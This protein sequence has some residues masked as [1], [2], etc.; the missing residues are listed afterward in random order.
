MLQFA[1]APASRW[2]TTLYSSP[3]PASGSRSRSSS[4]QRLLTLRPGPPLSLCS[5]DGIVP[6]PHHPRTGPQLG[7]RAVIPDPEGRRLS[8]EEVFRNS[9]D[10][11][12]SQPLWSPL[13]CLP[14]STSFSHSTSC[15]S[16]QTPG[17][18]RPKEEATYCPSRRC[19]GSLRVTGRISLV[20]SWCPEGDGGDWVAG[21]LPGPEDPPVPA[22]DGRL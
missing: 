15:R 12:S 1:E 18:L 9:L 7:E 11:S 14:I 4:P 21:V 3:T 16:L 20:A 5:L 22:M 19:V 8:P 6:A 10:N 17:S 13:S 2:G